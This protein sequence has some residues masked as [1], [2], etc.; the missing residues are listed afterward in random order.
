M[1]GIFKHLDTLHA[2]QEQQESA[3]AAAQPAVRVMSQE[4]FV[5]SFL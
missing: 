5:M 2:E 3:S 1:A 4:E